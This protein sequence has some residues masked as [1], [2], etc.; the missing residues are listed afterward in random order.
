MAVFLA[1]KSMSSTVRTCLPWAHPM[2]TPSCTSLLLPGGRGL[3]V[4]T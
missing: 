3:A 4:L 1:M 2:A